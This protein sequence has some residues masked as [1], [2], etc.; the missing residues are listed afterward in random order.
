M[1]RSGPKA[2]YAAVASAAIL[3]AGAS[4]GA[5]IALLANDM[6]CDESCSFDPGP[7]P[8]W[9]VDANA[10]EWT[11]QLWLA[12]AALAV[13]IAGLVLA[14][15]RRCVLAAVCVAVAVWLGLEWMSILHEGHW[16]GF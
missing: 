2:A 12:L 14:V 1:R 6:R 9:W 8:V 5:F 16:G 7:A 11:T 3:T 4:V 10:S 13:A 15:R